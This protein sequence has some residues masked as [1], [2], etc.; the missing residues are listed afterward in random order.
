MNEFD[1]NDAEDYGGSDKFQKLPFQIQSL[2]RCANIDS[3]FLRWW[4]FCGDSAKDW[5]GPVSDL[6]CNFAHA[7]EDGGVNGER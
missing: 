4:F 5:H 6:S 1:E 3:A 7:L 2:R